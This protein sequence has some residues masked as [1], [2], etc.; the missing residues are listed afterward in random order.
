MIVA[1]PTVVSPLGGGGGGGARGDGGGDIELGVIAGTERSSAE[2][3]DALMKRMPTVVIAGAG[4]ACANGVYR[5]HD[6]YCEQPRYRHES[7]HDMF[8]AY[9]TDGS[10]WMIDRDG[11]SAPFCIPDGTD[12]G[13]TPSGP[14]RFPTECA[15]QPFQGTKH[16]PPVTVHFGIEMVGGATDFP[17]GAGGA[18]DEGG[19]GAA[20]KLETINQRVYAWLDDQPQPCKACGFV[21]YALAVVLSRCLVLALLLGMLLLDFVVTWCDTATEPD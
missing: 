15:W 6:T 16:T 18:G 21:L 17:Q 19:G 5:S 1:E 14:D 9:Y 2:A 4:L 7:N 11:S 20:P 8:V 13:G 12:N 3:A 10:C